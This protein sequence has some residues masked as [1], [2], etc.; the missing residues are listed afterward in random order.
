[1]EK[2][3]IFYRKR[4]L[5]IDALCEGEQDLRFYGQDVEDM[6]MIYGFIVVDHDVVLLRNNQGFCLERNESGEV[7]VKIKDEFRESLMKYIT[8]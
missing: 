2:M 3:T 7:V 5:E 8:I 1:M 4:T 6:E